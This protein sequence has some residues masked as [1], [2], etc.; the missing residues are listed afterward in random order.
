MP[1]CLYIS[2]A[3]SIGGKPE[4][5]PMYNAKNL[6]LGLDIWVPQI[7]RPAPIA[8]MPAPAAA[9]AC[10][11]QRKCT[12][13]ALTAAKSCSEYKKS[14]RQ[15]PPHNYFYANITS[16]ISGGRKQQRMPSYVPKQSVSV[17]K[18]FLCGALP[19]ILVYPDGVCIIYFNSRPVHRAL[20]IEL[21]RW[22]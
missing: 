2:L 8:N 20:S 11:L 3:I 12:S 19:N 5:I 16:R 13:F 1:P 15:K 18:N 17:P 7:V 21:N 14:G 9:T 4:N 10:G 6:C 22:G